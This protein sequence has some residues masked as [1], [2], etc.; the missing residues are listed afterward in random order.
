MPPLPDADIVAVSIGS[1]DV[2]HGT[3]PAAFRSAMRE[4]LATIRDAAPAAEVVLAGIPRFRGVLP[5]YEPLITI[6]DLYGAV[7][8]R[9]QRREANAARIAYADLARDVVG[10]LDPR[11][12]TLAADAFHPG[13]EIYRAWAAVIADA[14]AAERRDAAERPG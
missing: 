12:V 5:Q 14:L 9:I 13:P 10:R 3:A 11:T 2:I 6:G 4:M 8:R 7:L 1:N